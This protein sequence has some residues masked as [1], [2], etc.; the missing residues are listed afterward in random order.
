MHDLHQLLEQTKEAGIDIYTHGEMLPAHGYPT[1]GAYSQLVGHY[2]SSWPHQKEEFEKF[3]G[4]IVVTTNCLIPPAESYIQRLYTTNETGFPGVSQI[5]VKVDG[6][7]D[8]SAVIAQAK[9]CNPPEFLES[10]NSSLITGYA[11]DTVLRLADVIV[12]AVK[13]GAVKRFVVMAGCDG[14]YKERVYYTDIAKALPSDTI[15]LTAG[16]AKYRYNDLNLGDIGGI[17][18]VIDAGQCN[19]SYSLVVI[20]M[21]LA[22]AFGVDINDL[23]ISY[24]IA[25]YEQKAVLVLL[26]LLSLGV[27]NIILGPRLPAFISPNVLNVLID[28]Y[29]IRGIGTVKEDLE[30][31]V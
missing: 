3:N 6:T 12:N 15:I 21:E 20:A 16:C 5:P 13:S 14:R 8:F 11:H 17:P 23:P 25:W 10:A 31:I 29:H 30:T 4:P 27:Q 18:R 26:C 19:D 1:L 2:G 24:D 7:K 9:T 28:A 22:K